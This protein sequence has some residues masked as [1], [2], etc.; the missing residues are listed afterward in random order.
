MRHACVLTALVFF[1]ATSAEAERDE[2][3]DA[4]IETY[5]CAIVEILA[6]AIQGRDPA[7]DRF[8]IL[9]VVDRI[10]SYVQCLVSPDR[11]Q[12]SCEADSGFYQNKADEPRTIFLPA[13]D[14]AKLARLGFSMDDSKGNFQ[15]TFDVRS[16]RRFR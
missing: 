6:P 4:F 12:I 15:Q 10:P 7:D 2:A 11:R 13:E 16:G 1:A 8:L 3:R 9:A 5:R 14:K